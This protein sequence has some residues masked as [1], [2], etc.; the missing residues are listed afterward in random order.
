[1]ADD[2]EQAGRSR[3]HRGFREAGAIA[4]LRQDNF[5]SLRKGLEHGG[6][7]AADVDIYLQ[8][9]AEDRALE[10]AIDWYRANTLASTTPPVSMPALYIWGTATPVSAAGPLN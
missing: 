9:L 5:A 10:S 3:H 2:P 4:R 8:T 6:V 1:M 7:P